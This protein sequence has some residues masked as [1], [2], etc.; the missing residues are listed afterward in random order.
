[1]V[2]AVVVAL[3]LDGA[4]DVFGCCE[5]G[6]VVD[7]EVPGIIGSWHANITKT[8][9]RH[10][11]GKYRKKASGTKE[12]ARKEKLGMDTNTKQ[13]KLDIASRKNLALYTINNKEKT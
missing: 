13:R 2:F 11:Q 9:H 4:T 7:E 1:M 10:S 6:V 12:R 8:K 5:A 3:P